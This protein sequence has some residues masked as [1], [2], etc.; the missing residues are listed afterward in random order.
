MLYLA[1][2]NYELGLGINLYSKFEKN[3]G[4][5]FTEF[6]VDKVIFADIWGFIPLKFPE[7]LI[8]QA[9]KK[10]TDTMDH[11]PCTPEF[12]R[13]CKGLCNEIS[14]GTGD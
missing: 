13:I 1:K 2:S 11:I 8:D 7:K 10:C 6:C 12:Y 9:I 3:W 4:E 5:Q 14:T